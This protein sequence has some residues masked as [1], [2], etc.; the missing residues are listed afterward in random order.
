MIAIAAKF[1][2]NKMQLDIKAAYLNAP[3]DKKKIYI[4]IFHFSW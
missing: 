4:Y 2:W 1:C 3:L